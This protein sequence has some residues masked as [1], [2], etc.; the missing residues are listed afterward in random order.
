MLILKCVKKSF[1]SEDTKTTAGILMFSK[2]ELRHFP[3]SVFFSVKLPNRWSDS[4]EVSVLPKDT[5]IFELWK[6]EQSDHDFPIHRRVLCILS[7][8]CARPGRNT[9]SITVRFSVVTRGRGRNK[10]RAGEMLPSPSQWTW[11]RWRIKAGIDRRKRKCND[12]H[13]TDQQTVFNKHHNLKKKKGIIIFCALS[14]CKPKNSNI[15]RF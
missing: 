1:P 14:N 12:L 4:E 10:L 8:R 7:H 11:R 3:W 15:N 6:K 2:C 5:S 9:E 13:S